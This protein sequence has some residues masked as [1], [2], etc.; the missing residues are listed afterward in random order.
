MEVLEGIRQLQAKVVVYT[1]LTSMQRILQT[2]IRDR[3]RF[4]PRV[5]NGE[6]SGR[7]RHHIV[8]AFNGGRGFDAMIL[9][10]EAAGSG[11]THRG[12]PCHH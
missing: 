4:D 8:E 3:F 5:L 2:V 1:R 6:V 12:D 10:P 11:S 7:N 9:S